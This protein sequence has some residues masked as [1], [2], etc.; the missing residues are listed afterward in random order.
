MN[1]DWDLNQYIA[2]RL[3]P[4]YFLGTKQGSV[5]YIFLYNYRVF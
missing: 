2:N 5:F 1:K 3:T 4:P